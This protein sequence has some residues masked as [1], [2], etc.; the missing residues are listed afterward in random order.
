LGGTCS[1][2]GKCAAGAAGNGT[3]TCDTGYAGEEC[4][5]ALCAACEATEL[6]EIV[7][8]ACGFACKP[9]PAGGKCNGGTTVEPRKGYWTSGPLDTDVYKCTK[10]FHCLG[11][12]NATCRLG[13][14][15]AVCATCVA[16]W[17][18]STEGCIDCAGRT[19]S[20]A[21]WVILAVSCRG[22]AVTESSSHR[23]V[24]VESPSSHRE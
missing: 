7:E 4:G 13:H 14:R 9:C 15:G 19:G 22:I 1:G 12:R 11:G 20:P 6:K 10:A 3:C 16:G 24:T 21:M 8:N 17:A 2:H 18:G 5:I 23:R